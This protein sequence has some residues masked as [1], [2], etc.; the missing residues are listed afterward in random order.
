MPEAACGNVGKDDVTAGAAVEAAAGAAEEPTGEPAA[1]P[2]VEVDETEAL[3]RNFLAGIQTVNR[4]RQLDEMQ[5]LGDLHVLDIQE[6]LNAQKTKHDEVF[7]QAQTTIKHQNIEISTYVS[8]I[9][10]KNTD[11]ETHLATIATH[12]K[13]QQQCHDEQKRLEQENTALR[14]KMQ[15]SQDLC[16]Q[17][18]ALMNPGHVQNPGHAQNPGH[19]QQHAQQGSLATSCRQEVQAVQA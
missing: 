11:I 19:S 14:D 13:T 9:S 2:S 3:M 7:L 10:Q 6:R 4:K 5:R 16:A 1:E 12:V 15:S 18:H 17:L 8:T